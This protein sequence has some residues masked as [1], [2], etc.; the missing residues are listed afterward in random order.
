MLTHVVKCTGQA[1]FTNQPGITS[2]QAALG[3]TARS[4]ADIDALAATKK[5]VLDISLMPAAFLRIRSDGSEDD[6]N[7]V[8]L[9]IGKKGGHYFRIATLSTTQGQQPADN[10]TYFA[11]GITPSNEKTAFGGQEITT[12]NEI[13][14]Y[15]LYTL[16]FDTL[17]V[18]A[19]T[20]A[21]TTVYA[22]ICRSDGT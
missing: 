10:N 20:L 7:V 6:A 12:T 22:D 21:S 8:E 15:W 4:Q 2:A 18:I 11:D 5:I 13:G 16:G 1:N 19:S 9:Y 14:L 17:V 3:V